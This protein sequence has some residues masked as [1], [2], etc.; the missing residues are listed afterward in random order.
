MTQFTILHHGVPL[1]TASTASDLD[2]EPDHPFAFNLMDFTPAPGY[3]SIRPLARLAAALFFGGFF[4]P[5]VDLEA[6]DAA[7]PAAKRLWAELE[8]ADVR[9]NPVAGRV[10]WLLEDTVA[11]KPSYWVD[12]ELDDASA[13]VPART[14]DPAPT[15]RA[16]NAPPPN[17][18][19]PA[20]D[21][22]STEHPPG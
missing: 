8:L 1:G 9:G 2:A 18:L 12:L 10:Y 7:M 6:A 22:W 17:E 4:G 19:E 16:H 11:G 13:D 5:I 14:H 20:W 21:Q 15:A 3:E